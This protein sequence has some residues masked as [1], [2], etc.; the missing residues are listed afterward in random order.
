MPAVRDVMNGDELTVHLTTRNSF[1]IFRLITGLSRLLQICNAKTP[2]CCMRRFAFAPPECQDLF[3]FAQFVFMR[4]SNLKNMQWSVDANV[5]LY[6]WHCNTQFFAN[7][8]LY[9][10]RGVQL[11][12]IYGGVCM[13][14]STLRINQCKWQN[15]I[16][17]FLLIRFKHD[18]Q[19]LA[20]E[21]HKARI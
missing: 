12:C 18:M 14:S 17:W 1:R 19:L 7:Q 13:I 21:G 16:L 11:R 20:A 6:A 5:R 9:V 2:I 15:L 3:Q 4:F 10:C 8:L